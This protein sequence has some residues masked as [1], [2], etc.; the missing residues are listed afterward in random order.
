[1]GK[2]RQTIVAYMEEV[3]SLLIVCE[4]E[5]LC[6]SVHSRNHL[7]ALFMVRVTVPALK[8]SFALCPS[9][10]KK[11]RFPFVHI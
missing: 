8:A 7:T 10:V 5:Q 11:N 9:K 3:V 1:M 4:T 2:S 6:V